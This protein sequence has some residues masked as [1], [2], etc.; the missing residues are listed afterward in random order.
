MPPVLAWYLL[1]VSNGKGW[2]VLASGKVKGGG[3]FVV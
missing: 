2:K 3:M 1:N